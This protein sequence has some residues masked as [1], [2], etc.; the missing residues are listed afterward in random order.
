MARTADSLRAAGI[1]APCLLST[2]HEA[3]AR[4]GEKLGWLVP[5]R[6]PASLSTDDIP[7]VPVIIH[8]LDWFRTTYGSD[9]SMV[10]V[11]Q[12]T[13]PLRGGACLKR[14]LQMLEAR[15]DADAVVTMVRLDR[16]PR[17]VFAKGPSG[18]V[19]PL[20]QLDAPRP[21]ATP[22]GALYLTRTAVLRSAETLTPPGTL[23]LFL[24]AIGSLDI[25]DESDWALSEAA[26]QAGLEGAI[27]EAQT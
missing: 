1:T 6:R 20:L 7:T 15:P 5:F 4:E 14:A 9:P 19:Q 11:L 3:I 10:L 13:S 23:P 16:A 21:L 18:F 26:A 17:H 24:D 12:L 8:A 27:I 2:D 25:D 22:N